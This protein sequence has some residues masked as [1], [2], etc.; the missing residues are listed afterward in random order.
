DARVPDVPICVGGER[1][2]CREQNRARDE[3]D[4]YDHRDS[5]A[6]AEMEGGEGAASV[7]Q[8]RE[9]EEHQERA[10]REDEIGHPR[11]PPAGGDEPDAR[12][13]QREK[14]HAMRSAGRPIRWSVIGGSARLVSPGTVVFL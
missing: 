6:A 9:A 8:E 7:G 1:W 4:R 14:E 11:Q 13:T 2:R 3:A 5:E 10:G 12:P